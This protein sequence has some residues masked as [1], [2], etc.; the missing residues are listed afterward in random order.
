[1]IGESAIWWKWALAL[2]CTEAVTEILVASVLFD[3]WRRWVAQYQDPPTTLRGI[4]VSC[5]YCVS[6]WSAWVFA[7][8]FWI[9]PLPMAWFVPEWI[10]PAVAG[11]VLHRMSNW[12]HGFARQIMSKAPWMLSFRGVM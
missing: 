6:L 4:L 9:A 10:Q 7:Y 2:V 3:R 12:I 8:L 5:G 11:I 1:M